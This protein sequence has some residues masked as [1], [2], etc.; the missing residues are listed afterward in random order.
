LLKQPLEIS[1]AIKSIYIGVGK[2]E[3]K[4]IVKSAKTLS[5]KV[6]AQ[7]PEG[8]RVR[9]KSFSEAGHD[10]ILHFALFDAFDWL[11]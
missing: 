3:H 2:N 4:V 8:L 6:L 10:D 5:K 1:P 7:Q 9:Y 11:Q